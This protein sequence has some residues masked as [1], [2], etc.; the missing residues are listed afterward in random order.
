MAVC[1]DCSLPCTAPMQCAIRSHCGVSLLRRVAVTSTNNRALCAV[2]LHR[3]HDHHHMARLD[4]RGRRIL[5]SSS[6]R[7]VRTR[8]FRT[9]QLYDLPAIR[10]GGRQEARALVVVAVVL[11]QELRGDHVGREDSGSIYQPGPRAEA[12]PA[13]G[14]H[15]EAAPGV[16]RAF[17]AGGE[18]HI[19]ARLLRGFSSARGSSA[20]G[21]A[22]TRLGGWRLRQ[23]KLGER[24]AAARARGYGFRRQRTTT[25]NTGTASR[26]G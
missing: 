8:V 22:R 4:P 23:G 1:S 24:S 17:G 13:A 26:A 5:S 25:S 20:G 12:L 7:A 19:F 11:F 18:G 21:S 6:A 10:G 14:E 16:A 2:A 3:R 9:R 15:R